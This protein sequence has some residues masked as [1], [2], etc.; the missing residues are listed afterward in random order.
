MRP[1]ISVSEPGTQ[2]PA[3]KAS[4]RLKESRRSP[5]S[6]CRAHSTPKDL[7]PAERRILG[8]VINSGGVN[9]RSDF[10]APELL[11]RRRC[12]DCRS[13]HPMNDADLAAYL[14]ISDHPECA[15]IIA[16]MTPERRA[17][18]E[19]M[20]TLE[21]EINAWMAGEGL[22][23]KYAIIDLDDGWVLLQ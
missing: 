13:G 20:A 16:R 21:V 9:V 22:L 18:Y 1:C 14:E 8:S 12:I 6:F 11:D 17:S 19:R 3:D 5:R 15:A 7:S 2:R 23:P 4:G 10:A